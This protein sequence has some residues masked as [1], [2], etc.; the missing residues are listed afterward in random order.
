M[1]ARILGSV[2]RQESEHKGER[3]R[4]ANKDRREAGRWDSSGHRPFGYTRDGQPLEP[5]ASLLRKAVADVLSGSSLRG[6][7]N[8]WNEA[9][10]TTT[11]GKPWTNLVLRRVLQNPLYAAQV[12]HR[13]KIIGPGQWE[14]LIDVD[15]HR[16]LVAYLAD[17]NRRSSLTFERK[18]MGSGVYLCG[19]CGKGLA[20]MYP[21][22]KVLTYACRPTPHVARNGDAL[23]EYVSGIVV[24][25]LSRQGVG[26][27]LEEAKNQIDLAE[28]RMRR[29]ALQA[30]LDEVAAMFASG[31]VNA[32]QMK[33]ASADLLEQI[34]DIDSALADAAATS[35]L[36]ALA[37]S[38]EDT[39]LAD[40]W[41]AASAQTKSRIISE[42]MVVT[43][44]KGRPG[45]R[46]FDPT[47][48]DI[49]WL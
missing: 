24:N 45:M 6:V 48:I 20:A 35:P 31:E 29:T 46:K 10:I 15:T 16:G 28:L 37:S 38:D 4:A 3:H 47:L 25:Y 34:A 33:R 32:G 8:R 5:E 2:A 39:T 14:A 18:H 49:E 19:V 1:V 42:L 17:P 30:R 9:G 11:T 21:H 44:N 36:A 27:Q 23:D 43:V 22:G 26:S 41:C 13:G 12:T 40:R 7:A